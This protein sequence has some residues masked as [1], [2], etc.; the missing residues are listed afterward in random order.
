MVNEQ[1]FKELFGIKAL[2]QQRIDIIE[3]EAKKSDKVTAVLLRQLSIRELQHVIDL[4]D[5]PLGL[6]K[7]NHEK[8][9]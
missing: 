1:T 9:G 8:K 3:K 4:F 6:S 2:I 5:G 7:K